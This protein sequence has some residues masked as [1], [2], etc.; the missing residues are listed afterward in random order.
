[1]HCLKNPGPSQY[2]TD[3][4]MAVVH[5]LNRVGRYLLGS[6]NEGLKLC[7]TTGQ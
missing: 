4:G 6:M 2:L 3:P 1:M 7:G 5:A